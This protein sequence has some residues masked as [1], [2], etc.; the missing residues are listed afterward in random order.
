[1]VRPELT[2]F[3][4][5]RFLS[6]IELRIIIIYLNHR[7]RSSFHMAQSDST[8]LK[9]YFWEQPTPEPERDWDEGFDFINLFIFDD[10]DLELDE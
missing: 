6:N 5:K 7:Y 2:L 4:S 3:S 10:K 8:N 1:M 9:R